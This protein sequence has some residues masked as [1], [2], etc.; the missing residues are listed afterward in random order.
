[1]D[2][3]TNRKRPEQEEED[4]IEKSRIFLSLECAD[5]SSQPPSFVAVFQHMIFYG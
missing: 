4:E 2:N 5:A 3:M 1:M